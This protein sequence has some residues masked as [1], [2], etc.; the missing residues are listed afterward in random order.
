MG[1]EVAIIVILI[2]FGIYIGFH[3][4]QLNK[5]NQMNKFIESFSVENKQEDVIEAEFDMVKDHEIIQHIGWLYKKGT[6]S[7]QPGLNLF[8]DQTDAS[9]FGVVLNSSNKKLIIK[10]SMISNGEEVMINGE[11]HIVKM[12]IAEE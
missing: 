2:L 6:D 3:Y 9:F 10:K 12:L 7:N 8:F 1:F 11:L 4:Y 5:Q